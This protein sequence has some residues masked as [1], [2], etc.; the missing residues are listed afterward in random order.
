VYEVEVR[1][2]EG[3]LRWLAEF[4]SRIRITA[5]ARLAESFHAR[6]SAARA[7]YA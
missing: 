6:L 1:N 5:P 4:G 2:E 7:Q 3:F